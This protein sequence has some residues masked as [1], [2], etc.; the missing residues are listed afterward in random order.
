MTKLWVDPPEGWKFGF[1]AIYDSETDG[2]MSEWII[3]KGYPVQTIKEYGEQWHIRCWSAEEPD[4]EKYPVRVINAQK[5]CKVIKNVPI[6]TDLPKK[7]HRKVTVSEVLE[8]LNF[9][10][11]R[12]QELRDRIDVLEKENVSHSGQNR[13]NLFKTTAM[14]G[15]TQDEIRMEALAQPDQDEV[16]IRS[17]LYQRIHELETQLAQ[18]ER[19]YERGFIDGMQKQ[20]QSSVDKAVNA[21]SRTWVGL[22]VD[23]LIDLERKHLSHENLTR[24]IEAKLKEKNTI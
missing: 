4:K 9:A 7:T 1:P 11:L 22:T 16:D 19:D 2:Q 13:P 6:G 8:E 3:S 5:H 17:R 14:T 23:E 10:K 20:M 12:I 24:A 15:N 21:M 18:P